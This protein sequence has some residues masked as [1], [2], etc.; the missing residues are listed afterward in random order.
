[1]GGLLLAFPQ[2]GCFYPRIRNELS[3][4]AALAF[5]MCLAQSQRVNSKRESRVLQFRL[6][7]HAATFLA[8]TIKHGQ[9]SWRDQQIV[10]KG[11]CTA[12]LSLFL[13][14]IHQIAAWR[15]CPWVCSAPMLRS[16]LSTVVFKIR[17]THLAASLGV[18]G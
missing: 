1:M 7:N 15:D 12:D 16:P 5:C 6:S 9:C 11:H 13:L 8:F 10:G 14:F 4:V 2:A 18:T 17:C 3:A